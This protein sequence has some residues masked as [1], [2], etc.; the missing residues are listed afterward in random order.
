MS[1]A[2]VDRYKEEKKNRAKN[3]KKKRVK[4]VV[5]VLICAALIGGILGYPLG[6]QMYKVSAEKRKE[7]ATVKT[8]LYDYWV[9]Q[10]WSANY[11]G[12]LGEDDELASD[13][14]AT[15]S[16]TDATASDAE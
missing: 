16:D 3:M 13:T 5:G 9:Q 7:S 8:E 6:K 11:G 10:Y 12:I 1:Q 15:A 14:D 2:K 4:K